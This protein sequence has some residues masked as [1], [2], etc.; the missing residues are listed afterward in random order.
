MLSTSKVVEGW[1]F[2]AKNQASALSDISGTNYVNMVNDAV[3]QLTKDINSQMETSR[4]IGKLKGFIA[5]YWH[6]NTFNIDAVLKGS[7]N[8]AFILGSNEHASV[9]VLT[10]FGDD[11]SMKYYATGRESAISQSKNVLQAYYEYLR[12]SKAQNPLTLEEY[13][14]K[15]DYENH[16]AELIKSVYY[17]QGRIIPSDQLEDAVNYLKRK[18]ATES[19]KEGQGRVALYD[20]YLETLEKLSDR[21]KDCNGVESIPLTKEESE[22]IAALAKTGEFSPEDFGFSLKEL[23]IT[24]YIMQQALKAGV[25]SAVITFAFQIAPEIYKAIDYLIKNGE[26]DAEQLK[27]TGL[28]AISSSA[29]GF[30]R[31]SISAAITISCKT[32]K[33][34]SNL[35]SINPGV[36]GAITVIVIDTMKSSYMVACG[37][38]NFREMETQLTKELLIASASLAGGVVGQVI[39]PELPV[40][41]Y[42]LGS[43][44][45]SVV[46]SVTINLCE[47]TI[48]SFCADTGFTLFGLVEQNYEM[49]QEVFDRLGIKSADFKIASYKKTNYKHSPYKK[50]YYKRHKYETIKFTILRRGVIGVSIIGY[51]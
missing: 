26:I 7:S 15:H 37:K 46:C 39:L 30:L 1:D 45:G 29:E 4:E 48:L 16:T 34:G 27:Y 13:L 10:N 21:I 51:I 11:Y 20:N 12:K 31:G 28:K 38:M 32:G 8:R 41:G 50:V 2:I 17:G 19:V 42:M 22:A 47:N 3:E 33:L 24:E 5:E 9:D 23:I 44:L 49:P 36:I 35:M 25:T 18:I 43:L 6:A 14:A 40:I